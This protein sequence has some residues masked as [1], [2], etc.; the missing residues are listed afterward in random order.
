MNSSKLGFKEKFTCGEKR[1]V[2]RQKG[3]LL[4]TQQL[5]DTSGCICT[6]MSIV[7]H[8]GLVTA[9]GERHTGAEQVQ[10]DAQCLYV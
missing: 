8:L 6:N 9:G 2:D 10:T 5:G 7:P 1:K 4:L 3:T